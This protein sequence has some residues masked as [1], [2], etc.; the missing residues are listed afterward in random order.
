MQLGFTHLAS[1]LVM[2]KPILALLHRRGLGLLLH[3]LLDSDG[4]IHLGLDGERPGL[5]ELA[6]AAFRLRGLSGVSRR[7]EV[8]R[9]HG[10]TAARLMRCRNTALDGTVPNDDSSIGP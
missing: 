5:G 7:P 2:I 8:T 3:V 10:G 4:S 1:R 9:R 6:L